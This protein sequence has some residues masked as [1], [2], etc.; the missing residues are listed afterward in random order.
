MSKASDIF[1]LLDTL[2]S[3][4]LPTHQELANPYFID[5]AAEINFEKGYTVAYSA[6]SNLDKIRN[7]RIVATQRSYDI[8]LT[9][10]LYGFKKSISYRKSIERLLFD[11][12]AAI[13]AAIVADNQL[14]APTT[15]VIA[16][17]SADE[18]I[19]FIGQDREDILLLRT[20][21][22]VEYHSGC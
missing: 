17:Y 8:L 22:E 14:G 9:R 11:D 4:T 2:V 3:T 10:K 13:I 5:D 1:D 12:Q 20:T 6:G 21:V 7:A 15:V 16:R 19:E 18:G